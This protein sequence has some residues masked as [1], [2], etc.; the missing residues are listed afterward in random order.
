MAAT[1]LDSVGVHG[2]FP[3][4]LRLE[5]HTFAPTCRD[6]VDRVLARRPHTRVDWV[7]WRLSA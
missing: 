1:L 3:R 6:V 5:T 7:W 2:I 4:R